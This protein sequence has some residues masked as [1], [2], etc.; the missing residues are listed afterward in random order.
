MKKK[1]LGIMAVTLTASIM[2]VSLTG[3][4]TEAKAT[5]QEVVVEE[6]A[7]VA[8]DEGLEE[9]SATITEEQDTETEESIA[10]DEE[11]D[12]EGDVIEHEYFFALAEEDPSTAEEVDWDT[13]IPDGNDYE[14]KDSITIYGSGKGRIVGYTKPDISVHVVTSSDDWY[15]IGFENEEPEYQLLLAKAEDFIASSGMYE[16]IPAVTYDDVEFALKDNLYSADY[17]VDYQV[18]FAVLDEPAEDMGSV[19]FTIPVYCID[20]GEWMQQVID[21][22]DLGNYSRFYMEQLTDKSDGENLC[23]RIYYGELQEFAK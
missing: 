11:P 9:D 15:C 13:L 16:N 7:M 23:F 1:I 8:A 2:T 20:V 12:K 10:D 14:L 4:G 19:E 22:N 21:D 6:E 18:Y 17:G 5:D 3:C